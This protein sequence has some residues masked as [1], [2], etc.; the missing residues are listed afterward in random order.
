M[1]LQT[2]IK[3]IQQKLVL[4]L[5]GRF[6]SHAYMR[7]QE[8]C[9]SAV[10]AKGVSEIEIDFREVEYMDTSALGMLL[11]LKEEAFREGIERISLTHC[12]SIVQ[13][14]LK[15]ANFQKTF[16][17]HQHGAHEPS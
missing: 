10:E 2:S 14:I 3:I 11:Y 12:R 4:S 6:D 13:E 17:L 15:V 9:K 1:T 7:F 16:H 5:S 8:A